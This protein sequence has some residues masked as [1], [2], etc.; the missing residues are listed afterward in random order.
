MD[1]FLP[2]PPKI[3]N[4]KFGQVYQCR[5]RDDEKVVA[6]K[7]LNKN[8]LRV[9]QIDCLDEAHLHRTLDHP[10]IVTLLEH[11]QDDEHVYLVMGKNHYA[12]PFLHLT[13]LYTCGR[14]HAGGI[15]R[16]LENDASSSVSGGSTSGSRTGLFT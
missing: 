2:N 12:S 10:N 14:I 8:Q 11:F 15:E 5:R 7:V 3:G 1:Q 9:A 13:F 4:G 6:L 16:G